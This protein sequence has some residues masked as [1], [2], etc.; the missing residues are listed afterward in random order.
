MPWRQTR[1]WRPWRRWAWHWQPGRWHPRWRQPWWWWSW[2]VSR[3]VSTAPS[4]NVK[5][6]FKVFDLPLFVSDEALNAFLLLDRVLL[7]HVEHIR[8]LPIALFEGCNRPLLLFQNLLLLRKFLLPCIP[9]V[10]S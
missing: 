6:V 10:V 4:K 7:L 5:P 1:R 9:L 8:D 3:I 2:K